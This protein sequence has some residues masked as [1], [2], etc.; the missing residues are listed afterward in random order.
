MGI[1]PEHVERLSKKLALLEGL[2]AYQ[3]GQLTGIE[4][5][6]QLTQLSEDLAAVAPTYT[7]TEQAEMLTGL[8]QL[9]Y[10]NRNSFSSLE[11]IPGFSIRRLFQAIRGQEQRVLNLAELVSVGP[12]KGLVAGQA[13]FEPVGNQRIEV[14]FERVF[15]TTPSLLTGERISTWVEQ[16][17]G[18]QAP[19]LSFAL[20]GQQG[21]L[22]IRY[23]DET[24]RIAVGNEGN[25]FILK[26]IHEESA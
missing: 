12:L 7:Q 22:E 26:R 4:A 6:R 20:Q 9:L 18:G 17:L 10:T 11:Q 24:L 25:L 2:L 23:V 14:F 15:I 5:Q 8:W 1:S 16:F 19:A 21:W 13:R 3:E